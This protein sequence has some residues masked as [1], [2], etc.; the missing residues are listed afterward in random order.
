LNIDAQRIKSWHEQGMK[1]PMNNKRNLIILAMLKHKQQYCDP[2]ANV[3]LV[4][5]EI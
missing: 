3:F 2:I 5:E 4:A 1:L